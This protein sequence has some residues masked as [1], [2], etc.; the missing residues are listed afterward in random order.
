MQTASSMIWTQ[1]VMFI[2]YDD[3]IIIENSNLSNIA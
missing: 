1:V 3:N 2:S